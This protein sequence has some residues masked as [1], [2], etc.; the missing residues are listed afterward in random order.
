LYTICRI[1]LEP[2]KFYK[3]GYV[4]LSEKLE[5]CQLINLRISGVNPPEI[6]AK[7]RSLCQFTKAFKTTGPA[8]D[9]WSGRRKKKR[10]EGWLGVRIGQVLRNF[11]STTDIFHYTFNKVIFPA[12]QKSNFWSFC[13]SPSPFCISWLKLIL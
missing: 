5:K 9:P 3:I 4:F 12:I 11:W 1:L 6:L 7:W 13:F 8:G 2:R 10:T